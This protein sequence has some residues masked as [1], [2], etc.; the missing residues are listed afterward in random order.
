MAAP[1]T[2]IDLANAVARNIVP[3]VGILFLGWSAPSVLLLYFADTMLA[4]GVIF[5]GLARHFF[6][7]GDDGW[8]DARTAR[9]AS[10]ARRC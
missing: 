6:P 9:R 7:P 4:M 5:A 3:L 8:G 1:P 10:S 2:P